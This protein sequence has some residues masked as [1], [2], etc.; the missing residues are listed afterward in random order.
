M[1]VEDVVAGTNLTTRRLSET[2]R[3]D[4]AAIEPAVDIGVCD[5]FEPHHGVRVVLDVFLE[6]LSVGRIQ[7]LPVH[8][9]WDL[10][11][12][13]LN[14]VGRV[15]FVNRIVADDIGVLSESGRCGVPVSDK[16]VVHVLRVIE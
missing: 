11:S 12:R 10:E 15:W 3:E 4:G 1:V 2:N 13:V 9:T 6:H 8:D 5:W 14:L 16:L 7:M